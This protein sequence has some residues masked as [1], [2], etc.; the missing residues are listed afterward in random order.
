M[1]EDVQAGATSV[2]G[3][4]LASEPKPPTIDHYERIVDRAHTEI[5]SVRTVYKWLLGIVGIA[6]TI[7]FGV[8]IYFTH[9]SISDLKSEIRADGEKLK[10]ELAQESRALA[11]SLRREL[12]ES[13]SQDAEKSRSNMQE[14]LDE[15]SLTVE[16]RVE[17]QFDKNNITTLVEDKARERIDA[18]ADKLIGQKID[19]KVTPLISDIDIQARELQGR[20]VAI[21]GKLNQI[22]ADSQKRLNSLEVETKENLEVIQ[23]ESE[24]LLTVLSAQ[25]GDKRSWSKLVQVAEKEKGTKLGEFAANAAKRVYDDFFSAGPFVEH[26]YYPPTIS[27]SD[28]VENLKN[29]WPHRRKTAVYTIKERSMYD[30]IPNLI[31]MLSREGNLGVL[32]EIYAVLNELL[33]T[34]IKITDDNGVVKF[35][36]AWQTKK[37]QLEERKQGN[38]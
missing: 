32:G 35:E 30:E 10:G 17:E 7:I 1:N 14:R 29:D 13:V 31:S 4:T 11:G 16:Q 34:D 15:L 28:V 24:F 25:N 9:Q 38:N 26:K 19:E 27:D 6:M 5:E 23:T 33:G 2:P 36:E 21:E 18:V 22:T 12:Q 37:K 20:L 3:S 8:G